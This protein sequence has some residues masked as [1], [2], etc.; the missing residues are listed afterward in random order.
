MVAPEIGYKVYTKE[1]SCSDLNCK[2]SGI[3][4]NSGVNTT[5]NRGII[6]AGRKSAKHKEKRGYSVRKDI[7]K[8]I[9]ERERRGG[10]YMRKGR[11]E[12]QGI[13]VSSWPFN[14]ESMSPFPFK[15]G[16]KKTF[17]KRTK[18]KALSD[19]LSPVVGFLR[20]SVGRK[21]DDVYSELSESIPKNKWL[22]QHVWEHIDGMVETKT[23]LHD[24]KVCVLNHYSKQYEDLED[25]QGWNKRDNYFYVHPI[26]GYLYKVNTE[27][28]RKRKL[29]AAEKQKVDVWNHL[30][31]IRKTKESKFY[32][33]KIEGIWYELEIKK[34]PAKVMKFYTNPDGSYK[35]DPKTGDLLSYW[36]R[37]SYREEYLHGD[38]KH[39]PRTGD[40]EYIARK[41]TLSHSEL[42]RYKLI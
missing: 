4:V 28:Q 12:H 2:T 31:A 20:K 22:N 8:L 13:G 27:G 19:F 33:V 41:R 1:E 25:Y 7:S 42:K 37:P 32:A 26:N 9:C 14:G 15:E 36:A 3:D 6:S 18:Y 5:E 34:K 23:V 24:G 21:W 40:D 16:I 39:T 30:R 17:G 38:V 10:G 29:E 11:E 35:T